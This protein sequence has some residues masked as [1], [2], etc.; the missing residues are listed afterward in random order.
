MHTPR[1]LFA[2]SALYSALCS[3]FVVGVCVA[4]F[5]SGGDLVGAVLRNV[6]DLQLPALAWEHEPP[7][8]NAC[9]FV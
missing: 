6:L 9:G 2:H 5:V 8:V 1:Y 4:M 3:P 7:V